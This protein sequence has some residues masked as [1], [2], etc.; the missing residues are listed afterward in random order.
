MALSDCVRPWK[1]TDALFSVFLCYDNC[2]WIAPGQCQY[3]LLVKL[4]ISINL[5]NAS[6]ECHIQSYTEFLCELMLSPINLTPGW[7]NNIRTVF[8]SLKKIEQAILKLIFIY[9]F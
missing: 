1:Q 5:Q 8:P 4:Y 3:I 7:E 9:Y 6:P 2:V